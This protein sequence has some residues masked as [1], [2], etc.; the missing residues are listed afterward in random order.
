VDKKDL[1]TAKEIELV[2]NDSQLKLADSSLTEDNTVKSDHTLGDVQTQK[3]I[4][5][6]N[7][8]QVNCDNI[9]ADTNNFAQPDHLIG[10]V[11]GGHYEIISKIGH[12][13]MSTVYKAKH[14]LLT[15]DVAIKFLTV[16]RQ[17]DG[18]AHQRFQEEARAAVG[19][20]HS[21]ICST[22]EFGINEDGTPYLVM[23]FLEGK[24]L[25]ELI[26]QEEKLTQAQA[27]ELMLGVCSGLKHA[28]E[29]G[30]IHRD[31]KPANIIIAKDKN[32]SDVIKI[33]DFGIAKLIRE[34]DSGPNLTQ[35]GEV[36]GTP[37]YMSPE[38][39]HGRKVDQR[40]DIYA[41]GCILYEMLSGQPPFNNESAIQ[42][43]FA[44]VNNEPAALANDVSKD[45]KVIIDR[46]LQ[47]EPASRYQTVSELMADLAA[48]KSGAPLIHGRLGKTSKAPH[49]ALLLGVLTMLSVVVVMFAGFVINSQSANNFATEWETSHNKAISL[50]Q[51]HDLAGAESQLEKCLEI[52]ENSRNESL[53]GSALQELANV[54]EA[55]GKTAEAAAHKKTLDDKIKV[56]GTKKFLLTT[57]FALIGLG[58]MIFI[59]S[60]V[61]FSPSRN[62][63][64]KDVFFIRR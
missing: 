20:Q 19:L 51:S 40:A 21:N 41:L 60:I 12:G 62:R 64:L 57:A 38:Q 3:N 46:C 23:D 54:E 27:I 16:G 37:K 28:H 13:G 1:K 32:G 25:G 11:I 55:Q 61:L 15:R 2:E 10:K 26:K 42:I 49:V 9:S 58:L 35:T 47:K 17:L 53:I 24:S 6:A 44:H 43:L 59:G 36:F 14:Q 29:S 52:A 30:V 7:E 45:M 22:R 4:Q 56:N 50:R 31:I 48:V 34:D 39:C 63:V 18:K 33:V 5:F 8:K